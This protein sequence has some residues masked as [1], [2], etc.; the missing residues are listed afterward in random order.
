MAVMELMTLLMEDDSGMN[1]G[2][3]ERVGYSSYSCQ[4]SENMS[5]DWILS[6]LQR[7][8]RVISVW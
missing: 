5:D 8:L 3:R 7:D 4:L 1:L 6:G 2:F